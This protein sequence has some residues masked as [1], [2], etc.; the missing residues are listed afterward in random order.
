ML[1]RTPAGLFPP[2]LVNTELQKTRNWYLK[3]DKFK[4]SLV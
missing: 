1:L 4:T 2:A 3:L